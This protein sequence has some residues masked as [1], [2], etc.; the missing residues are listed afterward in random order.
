MLSKSD[1]SAPCLHLGVVVHKEGLQAMVKTATRQ[2]RKVHRLNQIKS[3]QTTSCSL[4]PLFFSCCSW[5]R[6][7]FTSRKSAIQRV[8]RQVPRSSHNK[9]RR[10]QEKP[11]SV[12]P[13]SYMTLRVNLSL[14]KISRGSIISFTSVS[15]SAPTCAP[16]P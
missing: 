14:I 9:R 12:V 5:C 2:R 10:T 13:G 8:K 1:N 3:F 11:I 4:V 16:S 15:R 6:T 7:C